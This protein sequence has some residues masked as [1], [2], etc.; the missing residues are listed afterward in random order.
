MKNS[1][2]PKII[3]TVILAAGV[4]FSFPY[5]R[6]FIRTGSAAIIYK[7]PEVRSDVMNIACIGDSITYGAGVADAEG[8][9]PDEST[10]PYMLEE[11][12][13]HEVQILN[14]GVCGRT[15]MKNTGAGYT[16]TDFYKRSLESGAEGFLILLG[17]NDSKTG[18]WNAEAYKDE[19]EEF[20]NSY[21]TLPGNP[22]VVLVT[23]PRAFGQDGS[24]NAV[25]DIRNEVIRDEIVPVIKDTAARLGIRCFDLY[26]ETENH[27]EW[28][29][30]GVHPN[31]EGNRAIAEFLHRSIM[32]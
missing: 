1:I 30:D 24:D 18:I 4:F 7:I 16:E 20:V 31:M 32:G 13:N 25:Y 9:R 29:A 12:F 5:L 6:R 23:P 2:F 19:L 17:T 27:P 10:W 14:Y 8:N 22:E 11:Q 26:A 28:F 21:L 3:G 15:L